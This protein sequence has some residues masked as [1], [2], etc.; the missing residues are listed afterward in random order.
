MPTYRMYRLDGDGR[1]AGAEW[2]EAE[3][4]S[5]AVEIARERAGGARLE[6]WE[7]QRL[8]ERM[9]AITPAGRRRT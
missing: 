6:L 1:I 5:A 9:Q 2:I 8:V 4:D 7:G 3:G